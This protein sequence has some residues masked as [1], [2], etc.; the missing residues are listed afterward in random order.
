MLS[1]FAHKTFPQEAKSRKFKAKKSQIFH[2]LEIRPIHICDNKITDNP[3]LE[4]EALSLHC[5]QAVH[6]LIIPDRY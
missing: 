4:N 6:L 5:R 2:I 1:N 3:M